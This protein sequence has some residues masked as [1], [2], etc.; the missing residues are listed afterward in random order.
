MDRDKCLATADANG[1]IVLDLD[2]WPETF[3]FTAPD[4]ESEEWQAER[5]L[6]AFDEAPIW[7]VRTQPGEDRD[8]DHV[9]PTSRYHFEPDK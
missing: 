7:L 5:W 3:T 8:T 4:Y 9:T 1:R 2:Y 6:A